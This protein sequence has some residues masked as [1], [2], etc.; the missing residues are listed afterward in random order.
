MKKKRRSHKRDV[1]VPVAS[2]GDIAFLLIIFFMVCS[3]FIKES[4]VRRLEPPRA[5]DLERVDEAPISVS[6]D[7]EGVVYLQGQEVGVA[8][9]E[10]GVG[11]LIKDKKTE[12]GRT[13]LFKCDKAIAK[14]HFEPVMDAIAKAGARITAVGQKS[15]PGENNER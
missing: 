11:A 3:N 9:I 12:K 10:D 14:T 2:M 5:I 7:S 4:A 13:V 6:I 15:E 1:N 8:A